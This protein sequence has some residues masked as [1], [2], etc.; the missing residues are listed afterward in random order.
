MRQ[1]IPVKGNSSLARDPR[2]G[3]IVNI[4]TSEIQLARQRKAQRLQDKQENQQLRQR[5]DRLEQL[6]MQL[7]ENSNA[8]T[9]SQP[10]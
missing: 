10:K 8:S 5:V 2:T 9:D 1:L 3:A 6:V 7:I 4:N